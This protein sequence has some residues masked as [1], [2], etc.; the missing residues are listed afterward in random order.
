MFSKPSP[1]ALPNSEQF[2]L[3]N[4]KGEP[5]LI[6]ISWPLHWK[7]DGASFTASEAAWRRAA[8]S[9]LSADG[10]IIVAIGYPET[11]NLFNWTR[12]IFDLT[13]PTP[14]KK[15]GWGGADDFLDFIEDT[16]KPTAKA[17]FPQATFSR[18]ALHGH[19][20]GGL[21]ALHALFSRPLAYDCYIASSPSIWYSDRWILQQA[22][23]FVDSKK[24]VHGRLPTLL[25]YS[26][27]QEQDPP[28]RRSQTHEDYAKWLAWINPLRMCDNVVELRAMLRYCP[29]LQLVSLA[30]YEGEDHMS[31]MACSM[32]RGMTTFFE[33]SPLP[34]K[35]KL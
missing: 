3:V 16:V 35:A 7:D 10:G 27:S 33:D 18:E 4:A 23:K 31:V 15:P 34:L 12:R 24:D 6:Q 5:Y 22:R 19:S 25:L 32:S 2:Q 1:I 29:R 11:Q 21:F 13:P 20:L 8:E 9:G 28:R 14:H 17:R 26:G 30:M